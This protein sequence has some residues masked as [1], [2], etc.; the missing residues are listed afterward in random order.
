MENDMYRIIYILFKHVKFQ[1][2]KQCVFSLWT[3][4]NLMNLSHIG[5][6]YDFLDKFKSFL[7][8]LGSFTRLTFLDI[9]TTILYSL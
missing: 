5:G 6:Q 9:F 2:R 4:L 3:K 8:N 7:N 1:H